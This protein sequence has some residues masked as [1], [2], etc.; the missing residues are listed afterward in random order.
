MAMA[1]EALLPKPSQVTCLCTRGRGR[2]FIS[3]SSVTLPV[4]NPSC[5]KNSR[6]RYLE[7]KEQCSPC[8]I[9]SQVPYEHENW[10]S[11]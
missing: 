4:A 1:C 9:L 8:E 3:E 5:Q 10:W 7:Q 11:P 2:W 6:Y